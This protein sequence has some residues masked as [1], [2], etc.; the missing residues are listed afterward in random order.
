MIILIY[1]FSSQIFSALLDPTE[2]T[3]SQ[4]EIVPGAMSVKMLIA[5]KVSFI[6]DRVL[7]TFY[8]AAHLQMLWQPVKLKE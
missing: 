6:R 5:F 8:M 2:W 3:S 1:L 4:K 7:F